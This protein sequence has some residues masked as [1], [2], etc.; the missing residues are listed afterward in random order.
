MIH[1]ESQAGDHYTPTCIV[2]LSTLTLF[3]VP[4]LVCV[5]TAA[6]FLFKNI[7]SSV[8]WCR[9]WW[10]QSQ[11]LSYLFLFYGYQKARTWHTA[12]IQWLC[13]AVMEHLQCTVHTWPTESFPDWLSSLF[14]FFFNLYLPTH[15]FVMCGMRT[16]E[17]E[18][19]PLS[20]RRKF[21]WQADW[22]SWQE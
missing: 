12:S 7:Y 21:D 18:Y 3:C 10:L 14:F 13:T 1:V 16:E 4:S 20:E 19:N 5:N 15:P 8:W 9:S 11:W 17:E 6:V 22:L 2:P